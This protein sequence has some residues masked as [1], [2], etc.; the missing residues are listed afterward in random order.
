[1]EKGKLY[2]VPTV[3]AGGR[4]DSIPSQVKQVITGLD[5]FLVENVRTARRYISSLALGI[6]LPSIQFDE[7]TKDTP[8]QEIETLMSPL[9]EGKDMGVLSESGCPGVADPGAKAVSFAHRH[10]IT[11]VPL[12]GPSSILLALMASG[13]NGQKFCFH[14]YLPIDKGKLQATLKA[15]ERN[16]S[17]H[18]QAEIFIETP[19]RNNALFANLLRFCDDHT[20]LCVARDITGEHELIQTFTVRQWRKKEIDLHKKPTVFL[21]QGPG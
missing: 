18:H 13:L 3:I 20:L 10:G 19:Y 7:L 2:L 14:G 17:K 16:S 21:L 5:H 9:V 15:L 8:V 6:D 4:S 1:M 11:V 12:V